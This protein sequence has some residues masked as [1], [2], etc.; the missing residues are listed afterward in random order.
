MQHVV[1]CILTVSIIVANLTKLSI[2]LH[3]YLR[4]ATK[5]DVEL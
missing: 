3:F 1:N 4:V 5:F 2:H